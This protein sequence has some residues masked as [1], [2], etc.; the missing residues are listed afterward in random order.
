MSKQLPFCYVVDIELCLYEK[1]H[2]S[3]T[4]K[5]ILLH[6]GGARHYWRGKE[7]CLGLDVHPHVGQI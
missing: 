4:P 7:V 3:G 1:C 6:F 5:S 2:P